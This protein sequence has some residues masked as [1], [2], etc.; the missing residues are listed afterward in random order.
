MDDPVSLDLPP[1]LTARPATAEDIP[2]I[3]ELIATCELEEDGVAEVDEGDVSFERHG[4]DPE[5]DT[6]LVFHRD[7]LVAWAEVYRRR[8]EADV[9]PSHRGRGIGSRASG[10]RAGTGSATLGHRNTDAN[11]G[12]RG[13]LANGA[14]PRSA[15][16][17]TRSGCAAASEP[18]GTRIQYRATGTV[19]A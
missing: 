10:P 7:E 16:T 12:A 11:A 17:T 8:A 6:M 2:V 1:G 9:R 15:W 18:A 19:I 3:V 5:L 4:L 13:S 14:S